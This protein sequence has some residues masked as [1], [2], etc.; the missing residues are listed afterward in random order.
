MF[1][2]EFDDRRDGQ[3]D[4]DQAT[5]LTP[6][7]GFI[8]IDPL[9]PPD[10]RENP[11]L[12]LLPVFGDEDG[13]RLSHD[14]MV[15]IAVEPLG[16]LVPAG[17]DP[18]QILGQNRVVR[19]CH[20]GGQPLRRKFG[21][22]PAADVHEHVDRPDHLACFIEKRRRV[23]KERDARSV[24]PFGDGFLAPDR[25]PFL[26]GDRHRALIMGQ[27]GPIGPIKLPGAA[28][29]AAVEFWPNAP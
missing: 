3:R 1:P 11:R 28:E 16:A 24:R 27:G 12:L 6:P 7:H 29:L 9:A 22:L 8:V 25:P 19:R 2:A 4:I 23:G 5:V 10:P 13:H 18:I 26:Q 20:D 21:F 14:F 15:G 17:N